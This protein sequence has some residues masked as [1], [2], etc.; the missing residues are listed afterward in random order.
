MTPPSTNGKTASVAGVEVLVAGQPLDPTLTP[1]LQEVRVDDN[2]TLPDSFLLRISDPGLKHIDT[3]P[4]EVGSEIEIRFG[5][6]DSNTLTPLIK[7]QITAVEPEFRADGVAIVVRGYDHS[8]AL[9]RTRRN[10]TYQD[11]SVAD[12]V[13]KVSQRAGL[14]AVEVE[15]AGGTQP[16]IQLS[17]ETDL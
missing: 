14:K 13:K 4:L 5:A 11:T 12:V 2:L 15:D 17:Y 3:N 1:L 16:F 9:N 6:P 7:G 10:A 8:H